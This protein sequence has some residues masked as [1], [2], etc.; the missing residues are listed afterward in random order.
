M[1]KAQNIFER[2]GLLFSGAGTVKYDVLLGS[3]LVAVFF[4]LL[5]YKYLQGY[6]NEKR[7]NDFFN[8]FSCYFH[9]MIPVF[10]SQDNLF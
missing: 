9:S 7:T 10:V 5:L 2:V 6:L 3:V 4:L 8:N 1:S